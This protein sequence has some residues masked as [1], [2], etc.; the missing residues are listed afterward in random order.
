MLVQGREQFLE[1]FQ[2][3]TFLAICRGQDVDQLAAKVVQESRV[4]NELCDESEWNKLN[5]LNNFFKWAD[6]D[7]FFFIFFVFSTLQLTKGK[8][9]F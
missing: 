4:R 9:M 7:G 5:M 1:V 3:G 2:P 6:P 8:L